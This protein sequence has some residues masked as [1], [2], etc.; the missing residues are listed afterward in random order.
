MSREK[1]IL[2]TKTPLF[3]YWKNNYIS[4]IN[5]S[6]FFFQLNLLKNV[7]FYFFIFSISIKFTK[8][9]QNNLKNLYISQI[10]VNSFNNTIILSFNIYLQKNVLNELDIYDNYIRLKYFYTLTYKNIVV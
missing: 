2:L 6:N 9:K 3:S 10:W 7:I 8:L 5:Y 1:N 4:K